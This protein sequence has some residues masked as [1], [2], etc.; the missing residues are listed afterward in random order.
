MWL[1]HQVCNVIQVWCQTYNKLLSC[2]MSLVFRQCHIMLLSDYCSTWVW[3]TCLESLRVDS[4]FLLPKISA[5]LKRGHRQ[6][7]HQMQ[8][9][10]VT[11]SWGSCT[12]SVLQCVVRGFSAD[13]CFTL[14][15]AVIILTVIFL[16]SP[17]LLFLLSFPPLVPEENVGR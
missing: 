10:W 11:C 9:V 8:V 6:R 13:P 4:S 16:M 2:R 3:T 1:Y 15:Y 14:K 17:S 12:L 7:R 5:K